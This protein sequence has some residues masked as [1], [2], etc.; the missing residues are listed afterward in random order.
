L[1]IL[2]WGIVP[3]LLALAYYRHR[4]Y[5]SATLVDPASPL[6]LDAHQGFNPPMLGDFD[7]DSPQTWG[8]RGARTAVKA[9]ISLRPLLVGF[10][11]GGLAGLVA[12][13]LQ[14]IVE[15]VGNFFPIW[16]IGTRSLL[17]VAIR[18]LIAI[19]PI[20]EGCKLAA[21]VLLLVSLRRNQLRSLSPRIALLYTIAIAC[22]FTAEE[23]LIYF[24]NYTAPIFDRTFGVAVH[25]WFSAPWG[26]ALGYV[27]SYPPQSVFSCIKRSWRILLLALLTAI[28]YHALVNIL[29]I[30]GGYDPPVQ[31]LNYGL[32]PFFLWMAWRT[33]NLVR[34][35]RGNSPLALI[36]GASVAEQYWQRGLVLFAVILGGNAIYTWFLLGR[37]ITALRLSQLLETPTLQYFLLSR[38]ALS[39]IPAAI[40]WSIY[41]YLRKR[42]DRSYIS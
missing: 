40:A 26:Y 10:L 29:A 12:L 19:G 7:S 21:V 39:M 11:L 9:S 2:F 5:R 33:E 37:T 27:L 35:S 42:S 30:A 20:E 14:W 13:G 6:F 31:W 17:G 24:W 25:T 8:A 41:R 38:F 15:W 22:G 34:R 18:Q 3:P 23:N 16:R 36:S 4:L 1:S 32:F 28:A